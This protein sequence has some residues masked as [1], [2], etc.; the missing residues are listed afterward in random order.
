MTPD[1]NNEQNTLWTCF[2]TWQIKVK[3]QNI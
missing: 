2:T 3:Q 1:L